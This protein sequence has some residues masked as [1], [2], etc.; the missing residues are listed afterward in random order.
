[1]HKIN[2]A[3][4][5]AKYKR[6]H[7]IPISDEILLKT[8]EIGDTLLDEISECEDESVPK[9]FD[10]MT[11]IQSL[12]ASV[13]FLKKDWLREKSAY[14]F[15]DEGFPIEHF[16]SP[17]VSSIYLSLKEL[18]SSW[19][20]PVKAVLIPIVR[21]IQRSRFLVNKISDESLDS[22]FVDIQTYLLRNLISFVENGYSF[23]DIKQVLDLIKTRL[24][25][26]E[27]YVET[28]RNRR[29]KASVSGAFQIYPMAEKID[30]LLSQNQAGIYAGKYE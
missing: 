30:R 7:S 10:S 13:D 22:L 25:V 16:L 11:T 6:I 28:S 8:S 24:V 27:N 2:E 17:E 19:V 23:E 15:I 29:P 18:T 26:I 5:I 12:K 9:L 3:P 21:D 20:N 14:K 4:Q 1:M